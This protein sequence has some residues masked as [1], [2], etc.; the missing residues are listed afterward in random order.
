MEKYK[1]AREDAISKEQT[2]E[3]SQDYNIVDCPDSVK[4]GRQY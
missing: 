2:I 4:E 3:K 1:E